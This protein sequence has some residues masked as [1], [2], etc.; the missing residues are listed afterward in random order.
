MHAVMIREDIYMCSDLI[1]CSIVKML[2]KIICCRSWKS[3]K[4]HLNKIVLGWYF[5]S[6]HIK[7][8]ILSLLWYHKFSWTFWHQICVDMSINKMTAWIFVIL[9]Q[10]ANAALQKSEILLK[11]C[12]KQARFFHNHQFPTPGTPTHWKNVVVNCY[13][14][15]RGYSLTKPLFQNC[16]STIKDNRWR[17]KQTKGIGIKARV[18]LK[19]RH[20]LRKLTKTYV[21]SVMH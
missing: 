17:P 15:G 2:L 19:P 18:H 13:T 8:S 5:F 1:V 10:F 11:I 20:N 7:S 4:F 16:H 9:F 12:V 14:M 6:G 21:K 3:S